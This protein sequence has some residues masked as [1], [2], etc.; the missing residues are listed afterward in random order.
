MEIDNKWSLDHCQGWQD[1]ILNKF[2][3]GIRRGKNIHKRKGRPAILSC[4]FLL[5]LAFQVLCKEFDRVK[6]ATREG[7]GKRAL[8]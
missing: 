6:P 3:E 2:R 4:L 8:L 1:V 5:A 7:N